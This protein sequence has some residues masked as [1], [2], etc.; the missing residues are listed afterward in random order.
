MAKKSAGKSAKDAPAGASAK[1]AGKPKKLK[2]WE[3]NVPDN[4]AFFMCDGK[5]VKNLKDLVRAMDQIN[6]DVF[7][8]HANKEKNDFSK[9]IKDIM[10]YNDLAYNLLGKN[11]M[12]AKETIILYVKKNHS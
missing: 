3:G 2:F 1:A 5:V 6:D 9:W 11:R 12:H 10:G 8:H 4:Y 7:G